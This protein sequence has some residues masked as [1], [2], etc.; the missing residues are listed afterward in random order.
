[1]PGVAPGVKV[2]FAEVDAPASTA[3]GP[4]PVETGNIAVLLDARETFAVALPV[5]V[6]VKVFTLVLLLGTFPNA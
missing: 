5:L 3:L 6:T 4:A 2:T 1:L